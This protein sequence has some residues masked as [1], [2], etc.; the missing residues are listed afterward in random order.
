LI[1]TMLTIGI[2]SYRRKEALADVLN[3]AVESGV[4]QIPSVEMLVI[5]DDSQDGTYEHVL[6]FNGAGNIRVLKNDRRRG[7]CGNFGRLIEECKTEYLMFTCDDDFIVRA[8]VDALL[9]F[10]SNEVRQPALVSTLFYDKGAVYRSQLEGTA[11]IGLAEYRVCCN[12]LPGMVMNAPLAKA[13]WQRLGAVILDPLNAY[14]QCC[15]SALF[16]I[17]GYRCVYA[18]MEVVRTGYALDTGITGYATV[19]GRWDQFLFFHTFFEHLRTVLKDTPYL[20]NTV[21]LADAHDQSLFRQLGNGILNEQP[22]LVNKY[23]EG[24]MEFA[25]QNNRH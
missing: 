1:K 14:P 4:S 25:S 18:P 7:F 15:L 23:L 20:E 2:P 16:L 17:L 22:E 3:Q 21:L 9:F 13:L 11:E 10:L 19:K 12:H 5:D 8:G 24:A 6:R